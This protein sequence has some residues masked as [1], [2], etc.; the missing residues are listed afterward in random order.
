VP[1]GDT[2]KAPGVL[3]ATTAP[4]EEDCDAPDRLIGSALVVASV[5]AAN[6]I[7]TAIPLTKMTVASSVGETQRA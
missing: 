2:A 7:L 5:A 3:R 6:E 1:E 4:V